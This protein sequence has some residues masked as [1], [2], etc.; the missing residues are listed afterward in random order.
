M[1]Q[2]LR[3]L[4]CLTG[5]L[6][7]LML[8]LAGCQRAPEEPPAPGG[9]SPT[10]AVHQLIAD[11][12]HDDLAA[13]WT[14]GLAPVDHAALVTR[15]QQAQATQTLTDAARQAYR[16]FLDALTRPGAKASLARR[17]QIEATRLDDRYG[18]QIPVLVAIGGAVFART[19]ITKVA[20]Q[21]TAAQ[22]QAMRDA[23]APMLQWAPH[24]PWLDRTRA[25]EAASV[26]VDTARAL[27]LDN[28]DQIHALDFRDAI[29]KAS[30]LWVGAKRA[31]ALYGLSLDAV[32]DSAQVTLVLQQADTA[33]VRIDYR[34]DH[35]P[36]RVVVTMR[37]VDGRWYPE[38]MPQVAR[39]IAPPEW[40]RWWTPSRPG[41]SHTAPERAADPSP[42]Q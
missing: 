31:L 27:H 1:P 37:A 18:D 40:D 38:A 6:A 9:D 29:A 7:A 33:H 15:W 3:F 23:L 22:Q 28:L 30:R 10:A 14:H 19:V 11:L 34:L 36:Q 2:P 16:N 4:P 41:A 35:Q 42:V 12:R 39:A 17:L 32:L 13:F 8:M 24:A 20:P 26:A 5:L 25:T 21:A